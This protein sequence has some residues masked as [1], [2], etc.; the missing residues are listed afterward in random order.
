M[1][2]RLTKLTDLRMLISGQRTISAPGFDDVLSHKIEHGI[3]GKITC[4]I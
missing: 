2:F 4:H 1:A 3:Y